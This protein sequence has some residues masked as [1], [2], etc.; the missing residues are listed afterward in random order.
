MYDKYRSSSIRFQSA[1]ALIL[2]GLACLTVASCGFRPRQA[3]RTDAE[4]GRSW[5]QSWRQPNNFQEAALPVI[6]VAM[7][8]TEG[9]EF[10]NDD[11]ICLTCHKV[12]AETFQQNVH[13]GIHQDGQSCEACHG[14]ASAHVKAR[15]KE[16]GLL[17]NFRTMAPAQA[18]EVCLKCHEQDA[19][20][21]GGQW[22]T[23]VHAHNNLSCT[24]CHNAHYNVP[25]G[26]PPT[27]EP[28]EV[29]Q[30]IDGRMITP[31]S[32]QEPTAD[33]GAI[34]S[35][36]T[37][38]VPSPQRLLSLPRRQARHAADCRP[39]P[40]LRPQRIQLH[41]LPRCARQDPR[42]HHGRTCA[43][44]ATSRVRRPWPGIRRRTPS[45]AWPAPIATHRTP[46]PTFRRWSASATSTWPVPSGCRWR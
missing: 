19:C 11:E 30:T 7:P 43:W 20:S 2:L 39:A 45:W 29:A 17:L 33:L 24:S 14:P 18:A 15:G 21:P 34:R 41:H 46:T 22:R 16:P 27:T 3:E 31:V 25:P 6:R 5:P 40:D 36:P 1:A 38:W 4:L 13:R 42:A 32:Y 44:S 12:Y 37:T 26:T 8:T 23:S 35:C 28:G 9:A 10:V